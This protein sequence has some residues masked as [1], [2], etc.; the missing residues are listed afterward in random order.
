M[1]IFLFQWCCLWKIL[2]QYLHFFCTFFVNKM[3]SIYN[4]RK[5][6]YNI[7]STKT[8]SCH[9]QRVDHA[10]FITVISISNCNGFFLFAFHVSSI[11]DCAI[12]SITDTETQLW[13][14]KHFLLPPS[15]TVWPRHSPFLHG[16][17]STGPILF[18]RATYMPFI[19]SVLNTFMTL[20]THPHGG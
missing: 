18:Y 10:C 3:Q 8:M 16:D 13:P 7:Y 5:W 19:S 17:R 1:S 9:R 12:V 4:F 11:V 14:D 6:Q 2:F 20:A 15:W